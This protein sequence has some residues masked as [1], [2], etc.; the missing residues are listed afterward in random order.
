MYLSYLGKQ[1]TKIPTQMKAEHELTEEQE[2]LVN[3]TVGDTSSIIVTLKD[4]NISLKKV[5][6]SVNFASTLKTL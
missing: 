3:G 4:L 5:Q 6:P 2:L 1:S